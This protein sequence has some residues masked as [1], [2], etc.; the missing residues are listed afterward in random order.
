MDSP[1]NS[2][3]S[4]RRSSLVSSQ[5]T[6][7]NMS[8][9]FSSGSSRFLA[10]TNYSDA[11]TNGNLNKNTASDSFRPT[12]TERLCRCFGKSPINCSRRGCLA[13][14][15]RTVQR[16]RRIIRST[17]W[18][19]LMTA[20]H[21]FILFGSQI[22]HLWAPQD[23]LIYDI[24]AL[25]TFSFCLL[26]IALRIIAEPSYFQFGISFDGV[27]NRLNRLG[28]N[29]GE[30]TNKASVGAFGSFLFWCDIVST[31]VILY[32]VSVINA[33]RYN[34]P[35]IEILLDAGGAPVRQMDRC[36]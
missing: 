17:P 19:V 35:N 28:F 16:C 32:D 5:G 27:S 4:G 26:D 20:F 24:L 29:G 31:G 25:F 8:M 33:P 22:C 34:T 11:D 36:K 14:D 13:V 18:K 12:V 15:S 3:T 2:G 30:G 23:A 6:S 10:A 7:S 9:R 21:I 1:F